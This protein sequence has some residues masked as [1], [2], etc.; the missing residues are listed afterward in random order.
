MAGDFFA[1]A[2]KRNPYRSASPLAYLS[3]TAGSAA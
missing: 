2:K 3:L 1:C